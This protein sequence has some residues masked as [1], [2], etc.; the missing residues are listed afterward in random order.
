MLS[1]QSDAK[2]VLGQDRTGQVFPGW[3]GVFHTEGVSTRSPS[4]S[5]FRSQMPGGDARRKVP[6]PVH[7]EAWRLGREKVWFARK[8]W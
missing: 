6:G 7:G 3:E 8:T 5:P 2:G 1:R 4:L